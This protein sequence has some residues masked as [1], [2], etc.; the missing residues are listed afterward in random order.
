[1]PSYLV[2]I[3][4]ISYS[5]I[6]TLDLIVL[7]YLLRCHQKDRYPFIFLQL[8]LMVCSAVFALIVLFKPGLTYDLDNPGFYLVQASRLLDLLST[9]IYVYFLLRVAL[10]MPT[11]L[12]FGKLHLYSNQRA[13]DCILHWTNAAA[14]LLILNDIL[15]TTFI[16]SYA[17]VWLSL[18]PLVMEGFVLIFSL[19]RIRAEIEVI[20]FAE[21]YSSH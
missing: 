11:Y 8:A 16:K 10:L 15:C 5:T 12:N 17:T 13:I 21:Y 20:G 7:A 9:W 4:R 19:R 2:T 6:L 18:L 14:V 1:M 3:D